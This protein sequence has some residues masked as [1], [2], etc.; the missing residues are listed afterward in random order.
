MKTLK[1]TGAV[2]PL[3]HAAVEVLHLPGYVLL[4]KFLPF[5]LFHCLLSLEKNWFP[6]QKLTTLWSPS[7]QCVTKWLSEHHFRWAILIGVDVDPASFN[8]FLFPWKQLTSAW[9]SSVI[10]AIS[11][12]NAICP[13]TPS[14]NN[15]SYLTHERHP[16]HLHFSSNTFLK[17]YTSCKRITSMP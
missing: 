14:G 5:L 9:A 15:L 11:F 3:L 8:N 2:F 10:T 1:F 7:C 16:H 17:C 4:R 12:A 13:G 6:I